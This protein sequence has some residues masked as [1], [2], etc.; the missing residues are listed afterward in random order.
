MEITK[1]LQCPSSHS[2]D[3]KER[4]KRKGRE[5]KKQSTPLVPIN[6][7]TRW[8]L[9]VEHKARSSPNPEIFKILIQMC[10]S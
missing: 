9:E 4:G 8:G 6:M 7:E 1:P 10:L 2:R 3:K 5:R